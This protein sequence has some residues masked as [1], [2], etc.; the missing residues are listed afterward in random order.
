MNGR[1]YQFN[2]FVFVV[3]HMN[4]HLGARFVD[5]AIVTLCQASRGTGEEDGKLAWLGA[6]NLQVGV[7]RGYFR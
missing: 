3:Y 1:C 2:E 6:L 5:A 7:K 4:G